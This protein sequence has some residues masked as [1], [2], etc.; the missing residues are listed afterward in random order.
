[1]NKIH[2]K[3]FRKHLCFQY[4]KYADILIN[5]E[6]EDPKDREKYAL[7]DRA[8]DSIN[9]KLGMRPGD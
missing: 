6:K 2:L 5:S 1:M 9:L 4:H 7:Y 8:I 3:Q